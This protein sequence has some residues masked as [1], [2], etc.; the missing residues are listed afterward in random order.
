[1]VLSFPRRWESRGFKIVLGPCLREDDLIRGS[2]NITMSVTPPL[3][4]DKQYMRAA[5]LVQELSQ[6]HR[7]PLSGPYDNRTDHVLQTGQMICPEQPC[8][9]L[10]D[11]ASGS[12]YNSGRTSTVSP[13]GP[14]RAD[15]MFSGSACFAGNAACSAPPLL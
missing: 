11:R 3:I 5:V 13:R 2:L 14:G 15:A 6:P 7:L 8:D 12:F 4:C 9:G 1:M 10:L